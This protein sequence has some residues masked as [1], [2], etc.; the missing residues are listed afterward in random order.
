MSDADVHAARF[1][2]YDVVRILL[3]LVL[4]TA[5]G[6]KGHQLATE[7]IL[8]TGVL[9]SRW[10]LVGLVEFELC[11]AL[12]LLAGTT[13]R[14]AWRAA[15]LCFGAFA[16]MSAYMGI[17]GE[18]SCGCFGRVAVNPWHTFT[19]D[20]TLVGVLLLYPPGKTTSGSKRPW[21]LPVWAC[22]SAALLVG[23]PGAYV[24]SSCYG[25]SPVADGVAQGQ[26][27]EKGQD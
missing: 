4:L 23:L 3:G 18:G 17:S 21:R 26:G 8:A 20:V 2:G 24:M 27:A 1:T 14:L 5:A 22:A 12:W 16:C 19:L 25:L 6:L 7:P 11:F 13:P 15:V 10:F 9:H